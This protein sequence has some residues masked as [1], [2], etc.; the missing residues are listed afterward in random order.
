[1]QPIAEYNP[2]YWCCLCEVVIPMD[3]LL[4][5]RFNQRHKELLNQ[6]F[7]EAGVIRRAAT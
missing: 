4:E 7:T 1:M 5:H 3:G 2:R 6:L